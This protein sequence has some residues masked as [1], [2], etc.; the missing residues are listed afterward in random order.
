[1]ICAIER[2]GGIPSIIRKYWVGEVSILSFLYGTKKKSGARE[3]TANPATSCPPTQ[4]QALLIGRVYVYVPP[5]KLQSSQA[6]TSIIPQQSWIVAFNCLLFL[7][8]LETTLAF[9]LICY[10]VLALWINRYALWWCLFTSGL[11]PLTN[12][13]SQEAYHGDRNWTRQRFA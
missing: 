12:R 10:Q 3:D 2:R 5:H 6:P 9:L 7:G 11:R 13:S 8:V 1:M 4:Q